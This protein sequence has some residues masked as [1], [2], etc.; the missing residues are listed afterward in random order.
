MEIA[1]T[2]EEF[3]DLNGVEYDMLMHRHTDSSINSAHAAHI[4]EGQ[5]ASYGQIAR[6]G[7]AGLECDIRNVGQV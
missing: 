4:P 1:K 7:L 2:L 5:V 6:Q 3:L